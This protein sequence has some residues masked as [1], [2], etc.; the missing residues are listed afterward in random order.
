MPSIFLSYSARDRAQA[1]RVAE[2]LEARGWA[3]W[4]DRKIDPG[5]TFDQ[6]IADALHAAGAVVVLW[7]AHSVVS[8]WVREEA[9]EAKRRNVLVPVL[10]ERVDLPLGFTL[11]Q[12]VDLGGWRGA[13]DAPEFEQ[14]VTAIAR[15]VPEKTEITPVAAGHPAP[16]LGKRRHGRRIPALSAIGLVVLALG[17]GAGGWWWDAYY[18]EQAE[19]FANITR[20]GGAPEGAGRL[21]AAQVA[22]R[23][24][25]FALIRH[26][27]RRPVDELRVVDSTGNMPPGNSY[28]PPW[29]LY[30]FNPLPLRPSSNLAE[31]NDSAMMIGRI[32]FLTDSNGRVLEENA[33]TR[34]GRRAYTL[35][36]TAADVAEYKQEGFSRAV[37]E[38]GISYLRFTRVLKGPN[39]GLDERVT[40]LDSTQRPQPDES[41]EYGYRLRLDERGVATERIGLGVDGHDHPDAYGVLKEVRA[42]G[43]LGN[44]TEASQFDELGALTSGRSGE[45]ILRVKYDEVGNLIGLAVYDT[46]AQP[47]LMASLGAFGATFGYDRR[48]RRTS[49]AFFGPDGQPFTGRDGFAKQTMEWP[50][51]DRSVTRFFGPNGQ[52]IPNSVGAFEVVDAW[53]TRGRSIQTTYRDREGMPTRSGLG[54]STIRMGYDEAGHVSEWRC[55]NERNDPILG[56]AG[57]ASV[58][59]TPDQFGNNLKIELFDAQGKPGVQAESYAASLQEFNQFGNTTKRTYVDA[60]GRPRMSRAGYASATYEYD[61]KG[62]QTRES[63]FDQNGAPT[64]NV[65]GVAAVALKY[66][67][68]G[69]VKEITYLDKHGSPVRSDRGYATERCESDER[70]LSQRCSYLDERGRPVK[71]N[72]GV[73]RYQSS[74]NSAGRPLELAFFDERGVPTLTRK[75]GSSVRRWVYQDGGRVVERSDYD[76]KG[77]LMANVY[78]YAT[79]RY[80]YDDLGGLMAVEMFDVSRRQLAYSVV[81]DDVEAGSVAAE[82]GLRSGDVVLTYDGQRVNSVEEFGR[83]LE[84]FKGDRARLL[85]IER[86]GQAMRLDVAPGRLDG[87]VLEEAVR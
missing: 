68:R 45:A 70:R 14:L 53:D 80:R 71:N 26:G 29:S 21:T 4:W 87:L 12:A 86:K 13:P 23:A 72:D 2:A 9:S 66:G 67:E 25:S 15:V 11:R 56:V 19:Y 10:L 6:T 51:P 64:L 69:D 7:S 17:A 8:E 73:A 75:P 41:G 58:R 44:L 24:A 33:F 52:A 54:C 65:H 35:H 47:T 36:F 38:S 79:V 40:Y 57:Y 60:N 20:R 74:R 31:F 81:V 83:N 63:F 30:D 3:V 37:R 34:G 77:T 49:T 39:A 43:A 78:G 28:E 48:G 5:Q 18:R 55:F 46:Q 84:L 59:L 85:T 82:A 22:R 62:N 61:S 1:Q 16:Y 42:H 50:S 76:A 27:R 32:T